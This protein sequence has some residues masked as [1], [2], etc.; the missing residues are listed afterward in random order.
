M[1]LN[2]IMNVGNRTQTDADRITE[3]EKANF[4]DYFKFGPGTDDAEKARL[5]A[6]AKAAALFK[7]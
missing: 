1:I 4:C 5:D 7:K 2:H 6:L 3:K